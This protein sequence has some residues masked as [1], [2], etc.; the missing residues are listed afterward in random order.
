[1]N[2]PLLVAGNNNPS[3]CDTLA[4]A[5]VQGMQA[6]HAV[7]SEKVMLK[8]LDIAH[9]SLDF[10][11]E[12]A[13]QG[14]DFT[15]VQKLLQEANGFVIATPVWNFGVPGHLKNLIDRMGSFGLDT[16]TRR[17]GTLQGKLFYIIFTG[18]APFPAW[19]GMMQRTSSHVSEALKYFGASY[20]GHH[21][22]GKCTTGPGQFGLVVD[23]RPES[24]EAVQKKGAE[25]ANAVENYVRTGK[26]PV[27]KRA[28]ST[29]MKIG[30]TLLKK[31]S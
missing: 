9:F 20:M 14:A 5:F 2:I 19:K 21:F 3:N 17:N 25:F 15:K 1:M 16:E 7:E 23:K 10:Y 18:G 4:G 11:K 22:E 27:T 13:D 29:I 28:Q 30:E 24:L 6:N 31:F 26:A 8:D 12:D